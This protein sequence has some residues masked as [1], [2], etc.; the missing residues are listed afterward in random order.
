MSEKFYFIH[1]D[2]FRQVANDIGWRSLLGC[3]AYHEVDG[4]G[5]M[6]EVNRKL[7]YCS[8]PSPI[9][10]NKV[11]D[12]SKF[13]YGVK[14]FVI[15]EPLKLKIETSFEGKI[16]FGE[17]SVP[18]EIGKVFNA[19]RLATGFPPLEAFHCTSEPI[20]LHEMISF[21]RCF[22]PFVRSFRRDAKTEEVCSEIEEKNRL[23]IAKGRTSVE[24]SH[25]LPLSK[26]TKP[27]LIPVRSPKVETDHQQERAVEA[28]IAGLLS[29]FRAEEIEQITPNGVARWA[30][31]FPYERDEDKYI[32]LSE[33][34]HLMRGKY[35]YSRERA[36][37]DIHNLIHQLQSFCSKKDWGPID[38]IRRLNFANHKQDYGHSRFYMLEMLNGELVEKFGFGIDQCGG[39]NVLVYIDDCLYTGVRLKKEV[40]KILN[41][42]NS[43]SVNELLIWYPVVHLDGYNEQKDYLIG[44]HR[45]DPTVPFFSFLPPVM[46]IAN[47]KW[48]NLVIECIWPK[49]DDAEELV[50]YLNNI[51]E[52]TIWRRDLF[53]PEG[54]PKAETVFS[55]SEGRDMVEKLFLRVGIKLL[56]HPNMHEHIRPLGFDYSD[57]LGFG[58]LFISHRNIANNCPLAL[59]F[60]SKQPGLEWY[61]LLRRKHNFEDKNWS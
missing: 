43:V 23:Q 7:F 12:L 39:S 29:D 48:A 11:H 19:F 50:E 38:G 56:G 30:D 28:E 34:R 10:S 52:P 8:I 14:V 9:R 1:P 4:F 32:L 54:T 40:H 53:R 45:H 49:R 5:I 20:G 44:L 15:P 18:L 60:E 33:M 36:R 27:V 61:P 16:Y 26:L 41:P 22:E 47:N 17:V 31:Q 37:K 25:D 51:S 13:S 42:E 57:P 3:F 46:T 59:W 58:S 24:N 21:N 6:V 55:S 35:Y 2:H